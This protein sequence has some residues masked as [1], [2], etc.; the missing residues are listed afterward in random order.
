MR[1]DRRQRQAEGS[2]TP[3]PCAKPPAPA[4]KFSGTQHPQAVRTH[5][6][7]VHLTIQI[8]C[9]GRGGVGCSAHLPT[10][11][12]PKLHGYS[13]AWDMVTY[14]HGGRA[15]CW[16]V[17]GLGKCSEGWGSSRL[18]EGQSQSLS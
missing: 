7:G 1:Q 2:P 16:G 8:T 18:C 12:K 14:L 10:C 4:Q 11:F 6:F 15:G 17:P 5:T 3:G 9:K 13:Q